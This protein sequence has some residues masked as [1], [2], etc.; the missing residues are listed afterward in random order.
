MFTGGGVD[1]ADKAVGN[2]AGIARLELADPL[3]GVA[4]EIAGDARGNAMQLD[5]AERAHGAELQ[6]VHAVVHRR[7]RGLRDAGDGFGGGVGAGH[8][9]RI[10]KPTVKTLALGYMSEVVLSKPFIS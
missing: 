9:H 3:H 4:L 6:L 7:L 2:E 1:F 10:E 8:H 5:L